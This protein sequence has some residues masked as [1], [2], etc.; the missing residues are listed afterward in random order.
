MQPNLGFVVVGGRV[1]KQN[2]K[3]FNKK[4]KIIIIQ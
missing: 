4:T 3:L 2:Q 1:N